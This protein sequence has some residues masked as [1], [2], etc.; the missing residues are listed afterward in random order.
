MFLMRASSSSIRKTVTVMA[1]VVGGTLMPASPAHATFPGENGR[2]VFSTDW[3][4]PSQVYSI[5]P[6]GTGLRQL[7]HVTKGAGATSPAWS[8]DGTRIA[9][10][11]HKH[12]W[13]MKGDGSG[14]TQITT[15]EGF[16]DRH[17]AWSPDG[18]RIVFSHCDI[19]LGFRAYCDIDAID[20]VEGNATTLLAGNWIYDW[21]RYSPDGSRIVFSGDRDGYICAVWEMEADGGNPERL[22]D[23]AMQATHPDWSPD[24]EQIV[25][26]THCLLPGGRVWT[27]DPDGSDRRLITDDPDPAVDWSSPRF[28]PDGS[29]LLATGPEGSLFILDMDGNVLTDLKTRDLR[30][31]QLDWGVKSAPAMTGGE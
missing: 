3:S 5:R 27:M 14:Q 15:G 12:I 18:T 10:D 11:Y 9:F 30:P 29:S 26:S 20:V 7:T 8:P 25:F 24:G 22:T 2:I 17:A 13:V 28:A 1:L 6:D 31:I 16:R 23:P 21:P 19:S 4:P